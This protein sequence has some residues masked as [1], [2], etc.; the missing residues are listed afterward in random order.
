[1]YVSN[2]MEHGIMMEVNHVALYCVGKL[3]W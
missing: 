1:M 3:P 2:V